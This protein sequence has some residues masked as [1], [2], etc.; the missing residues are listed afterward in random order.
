MRLGRPPEPIASVELGDPAAHVRNFLRLFEQLLVLQRKDLFRRRTIGHDRCLAIQY[1]IAH[2]SSLA[3]GLPGLA[4]RLTGSP[5]HVYRVSSSLFMAVPRSRSDRVAVGGHAELAS[6]FADV[7]NVSRTGVLVETS[8]Q[9]QLGD[10]WPL[11]LELSKIPIRV[12]A[13]VARCETLA[14]RRGARPIYL[15]GM[16]FVNLSPEAQSLLDRVCR[17]PHAPVTR[18]HVSISLTRRC[19]ECRSHA[20]MKEGRHRYVCS[21]CDHHFSGMRIGVIRVAR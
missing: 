20:V 8:H 18:R 11:I 4:S 19:P 1:D 17:A 6:A 16:T 2:K 7:I 10:E 14:V 13:R 15:L 9:H 21:D 3:N 5:A 12:V